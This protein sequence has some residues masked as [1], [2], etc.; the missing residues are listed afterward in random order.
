MAHRG[1]KS[2]F[3]G[4]TWPE[5]TEGAIRDALAL[6]FLGGIEFDVRETSDGHFVLMHDETVDRTCKDKRFG[7]QV[8]GKV[9]ELSLADI[10]GLDAGDGKPPPE[11]SKILEMIAKN[12]AEWRKDR[13]LKIFIDFKEG[14]AEHLSS[15]LNQA[16]LNYQLNAEDICVL[17]PNRRKLHTIKEEIPRIGIGLQHIAPFISRNKAAHDLKKEDYSFISPNR[18]LVRFGFARFTQKAEISSF[19][20]TVNKKEDV[21]RVVKKGANYICTDD[22]LKMRDMLAEIRTAKSI[23]HSI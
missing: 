10:A 4:G 2:P 21:E 8:H 11:L 17:A 20:W 18:Y 9:S 3:L 14:N 12:N 7:R 16:F 6:D 19:V 1:Y 22:P 15:A 5:N 23:G 13:P